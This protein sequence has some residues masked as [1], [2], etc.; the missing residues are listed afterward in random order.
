MLFFA[1]A[2]TAWVSTLPAAAQDPTHHPT[3][4]HGQ[5]HSQEHGTETHH[6]EHSF[7][8]VERYAKAFDDPARAAW[9]MPERVLEVLDIR[10]GQVVADIGAGTG[11]FTVRIAQSTPARTVYAVDIEPAMVDYLRQRAEQAGLDNVIAVLA[12]QDSAGLPE[13]ADL[14]LIVDTYHHL[15]DRVA[16]FTNLHQQM[17]PGARL[18]IVDYK[19]GA[20]GGGPPDQFRFTPEQ[21]NDELT[22]A[23]F[24]LQSEHGFL[25]RQNFLIFTARADTAH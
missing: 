17:R 20:A 11:Y 8:D 22:K 21:I 19:K 2:G 18:A 25:P 23:G 6:M 9:Q 5:E 12:Q 3:Q 7:R 4:E 16:Y 15:P 14:V 1:F 10:A 24:E 13:P